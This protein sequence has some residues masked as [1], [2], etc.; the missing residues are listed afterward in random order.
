[1]PQGRLHLAVAV[2]L[3]MP[4]RGERQRHQRGAEV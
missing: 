3:K 1:M 2:L 4:T